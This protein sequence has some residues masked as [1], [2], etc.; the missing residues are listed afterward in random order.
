MV[1]A[2]GENLLRLFCI[3][4]RF[5]VSAVL[6]TAIAGKPAPTGPAV[7]HKFCVH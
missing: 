5:E 3:D 2:L 6:A 1:R 4:D 7:V